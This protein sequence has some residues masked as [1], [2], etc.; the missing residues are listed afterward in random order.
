VC[1][2]VSVSALIMFPLAYSCLGR[3]R[4]QSDCTLAALDWDAGLRQLISRRTNLC[5]R[6]VCVTSLG[7]SRSV[8][9]GN[10]FGARHFKMAENALDWPRN[11][12]FASH[13]TMNHSSR[14]SVPPLFCSNGAQPLH[15]VHWMNMCFSQIN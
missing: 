8:H 14:G 13:M 5:P 6:F 2:C 10:L 11:C 7:D 4:A 1:V 15:G 3:K 9:R 12:L